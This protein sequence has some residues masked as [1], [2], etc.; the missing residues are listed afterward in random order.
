LAPLD[1]PV[2]PPGFKPRGN[3][4]GF[5]PEILLLPVHVYE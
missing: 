4:L 3:P 1:L 2:I 5:P